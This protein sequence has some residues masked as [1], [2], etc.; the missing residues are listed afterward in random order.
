MTWK[1]HSSRH[2]GAVHILDASL[3]VWRR[4]W[5]AGAVL[6]ATAEPKGWLIADRGPRVAPV[7]DDPTEGGRWRMLGVGDR[8]PEGYQYRLR[9]ALVGLEIDDVQRREYRA[10]VA[11]ARA[12]ALESTP[13]LDGVPSLDDLAADRAAA[14]NLGQEPLR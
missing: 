10:P 1:K 12:L 8:R 9:G 11:P 7:A 3:A 2:G 13:T 14:H 6:T 5:P 4:D